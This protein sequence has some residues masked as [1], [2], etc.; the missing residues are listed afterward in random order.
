MQ[1][2]LRVR[3]ARIAQQARIGDDHRV[4]AQAHGAIDRCRPARPV[5]GQRIGVDGEE[6]LAAAA[7]GIVDA[8]G[9]RRIV[10]IETREIARVG[11]VAQPRIDPVRAVVDGRFQRRQAARGADEFHLENSRQRRHQLLDVDQVAPGQAR[12]AL[13]A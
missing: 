11:V 2:E 1:L 4:G 12:Q 5:L 6:H 7:V 8:R 3:E 9:E 13:P 10:E